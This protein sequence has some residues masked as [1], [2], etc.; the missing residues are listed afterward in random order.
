MDLPFQSGD[1]PREDTTVSQS[2]SRIYGRPRRDEVQRGYANILAINS[3]SLNVDTTDEEEN[4][5][6]K[7]LG[8]DKPSFQNHAKREQRPDDLVKG[9]GVP[10]DSGSKAEDVITIADD[11]KCD[12]GCWV[13]IIIGA[14]FAVILFIIVVLFIGGIC[15]SCVGEFRKQKKDKQRENSDLVAQNFE[16]RTLDAAR[17]SIPHPTTSSQIPD[18]NSLTHQFPT[19]SPSGSAARLIAERAAAR[20]EA[21][22]RP[23]TPYG[24]NST[25]SSLPSNS[26]TAQPTVPQ[27][28]PPVYEQQEQYVPFRPF[29]G[30]EGP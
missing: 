7:L 28:P 10:V 4:W 9:I 2:N 18:R 11:S 14:L 19:P 24:V 23:L 22:I 21:S 1:H 27:C 3:S 12:A 6:D 16:M 13:E 30:P 5:I 20:R 25:S 8:L 15:A 17:P 29:T 26:G